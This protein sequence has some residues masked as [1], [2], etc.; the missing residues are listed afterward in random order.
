LGFVACVHRS[1]VA[2]IAQ[3]RSY[4]L[5]TIGY[6]VFCEE[7]I[8]VTRWNKRRRRKKKG[9]VGA[10]SYYSL[11]K[12]KGKKK[13]KKEKKKKKGG[14]GGRATARLWLQRL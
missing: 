3:A 6:K 9:R 1:V 5:G 8:V 13:K 2:I 10:M 12:Q 14:E 7:W 4:R 11:L